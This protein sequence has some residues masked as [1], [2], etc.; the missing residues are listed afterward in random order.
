MSSENS[1]FFGTNFYKD[2]ASASWHHLEKKTFEVFRFRNG[3]QNRVI[4]CLFK[5]PQPTSRAA[6]INQCRRNGIAE[7][8]FTDMM[9]AGECREQAVLRQKFK[10]AHMQ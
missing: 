5:S 7:N 9:R 2:I 6:R 8:S 3:G 10:G 1:R 4:R